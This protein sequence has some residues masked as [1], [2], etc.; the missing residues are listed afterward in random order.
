MCIRD[1]V[2]VKAFANLSFLILNDSLS[3]AFRDIFSPRYLKLLVFLI[4]PYV[5]S[6]HV[7]GNLNRAVI[8]SGLAK[9]IWRLVIIIIIILSRLGVRCT[10]RRRG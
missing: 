7:F 4:S 2:R 6:R 8:I 1:R 10:K 9:E 3:E 5:V